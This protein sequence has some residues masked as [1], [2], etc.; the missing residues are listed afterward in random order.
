MVDRVLSLKS[1]ELG[2]PTPSPAGD[3]PWQTLVYFRLYTYCV[4]YSSLRYRNN[5]R[6]VA[7]RKQILSG[8]PP[9]A[10]KN[11]MRLAAS[12]IQIVP[13]WPPVACN[14]YPNV[15]PVAGELP[16]ILLI[17]HATGGHAHT[18]CMRLVATRVKLESNWWQVQYQAASF[19]KAR[20]QN[21]YFNWKMRKPLQ[22]P[23]KLRDIWFYCKRANLSL[24]ARNY[25]H[26]CRENKPKTLVFYDWIRALWACFHKN[27][28]L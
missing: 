22:K 10:C 16:A 8:W 20:C 25:R 23:E 6:L 26:S 12:R 18:I 7:S 17:L 27:A 24:S 19:L 3:P 13:Q 15:S 14:L 1:S 11:D 2:P 28:G 5:V 21:N 4:V 9:V